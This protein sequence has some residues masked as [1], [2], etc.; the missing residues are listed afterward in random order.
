MAK[1]VSV[2]GGLNQ[3]MT[4]EKLVNELMKDQPNRQ[5]VKKLTAELGLEYSVDPMTQMNT[6]LQSMNSV[7]LHSNRR[8]DLER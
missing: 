5:L 1:S 7:L 8:E 6:V 2:S 3:Q 4:L